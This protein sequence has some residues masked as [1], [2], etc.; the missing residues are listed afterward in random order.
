MTNS[1]IVWIEQPK[2]ATL[3]RPSLSTITIAMMQATS[4]TV[5]SGTVTVK[6]F[7]DPGAYGRDHG[8]ES[9][10]DISRQDHDLLYAVVDP[11]RKLFW[12]CNT[13]EM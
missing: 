9:S 5:V 4:W 7:S 1:L 13:R 11:L 10:L 12:H 8:R 6:A 3:R 2:K